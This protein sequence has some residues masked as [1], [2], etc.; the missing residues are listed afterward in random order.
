MP[1]HLIAGERSRDGWDVP[2]WARDQAASFDVVQGVGHLMML[3]D[4]D[5]FGRLLVRIIKTGIERQVP[6]L[7]R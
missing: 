4:G 2:P 1:V 5:G 6:C 7:R 3:E